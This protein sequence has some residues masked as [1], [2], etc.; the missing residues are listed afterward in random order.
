MSILLENYIKE[1][2]YEIHDL[3]LQ[4]IS[5]KD[6]NP[7]TSLEAGLQ[8]GTLSLLSFLAIE[9]NKTDE[10]PENP[11]EQVELVD[12]T[13]KDIG[14]NLK[15]GQKTKLK[16]KFATTPLPVVYKKIP[17]E[18][19]SKLRAWLADKVGGY[20]VSRGDNILTRE[21]NKR[22][23]SLNGDKIKHGKDPITIDEFVKLLEMEKEIAQSKLKTN[24]IYSKILKFD[25]RG[26]PNIDYNGVGLDDDG[27][28]NPKLFVSQADDISRKIS[29]L[30]SSGV[31]DVYSEEYEALSNIENNLTSIATFM[32]QLD[33]NGEWIA[34]EYYNENEILQAFQNANEEVK[35]IVNTYISK[36][37]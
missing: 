15:P 35:G 14:L 9:M 21:E 13:A 17:G 31:N 19:K 27:N 26:I 25:D 22:F 20:S 8:I 2:L 7:K 34:G 11:Q 10:I 24:K 16:Y 36:K 28:I 12:N 23:E 18:I 4:E 3:S 37:S 30:M 32:D 29:D 6:F 1:A 5:L 33:E